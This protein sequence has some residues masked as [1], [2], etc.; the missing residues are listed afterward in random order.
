MATDLGSVAHCIDGMTS[1]FMITLV[2]MSTCVGVWKTLSYIFLVIPLEGGYVSRI[3][4]SKC[5]QSRV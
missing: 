3:I 1:N 4:K 2:T 5:N